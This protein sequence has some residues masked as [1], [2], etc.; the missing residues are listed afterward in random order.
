MLACIHIMVLSKGFIQ[1]LDVESSHQWRL[2]NITMWDFMAG[3]LYI[4]GVQL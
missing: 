2:I 4:K 3:G 1:Y